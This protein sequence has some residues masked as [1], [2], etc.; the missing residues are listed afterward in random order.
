[1]HIV[2]AL[3]LWRHNKN[4]KLVTWQFNNT[5]ILFQ[6]LYIY[7]FLAIQ[8]ILCFWIHV[9]GLLHSGYCDCMCHNSEHLLLIKRR[10]L[11]MVCEKRLCVRT[12]IIEICTY[13]QLVNLA[14]W[15]VANNSEGCKKCTMLKDDMS[16]MF[17]QYRCIAKARTCFH[18]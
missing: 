13:R 15:M 8:D 7:I 6:V 16:L 17:I 1:M 4:I 14:I 3:H 10:R 5:I 11:S 18:D 9:T 12:C 2:C